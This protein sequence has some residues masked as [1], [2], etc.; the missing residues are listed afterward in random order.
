[1]GISR[2]VFDFA[3]M[4]RRNAAAGKPMPVPFAAIENW[5]EGSFQ[6]S[7]FN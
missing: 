7:D 5:L 2:P 6:F 3:A 4:P 1:M